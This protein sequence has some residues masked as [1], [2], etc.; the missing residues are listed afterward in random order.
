MRFTTLDIKENKPMVRFVRSRVEAIGT[1]LVG[2]NLLNI[3]DSDE[4]IDILKGK[5]EKHKK[6]SNLTMFV[7]MWESHI[8]YL[9]KLSS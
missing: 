9:E 2:D 4:V 5:I 3:Y 8:K 7:P 1:R 6:A